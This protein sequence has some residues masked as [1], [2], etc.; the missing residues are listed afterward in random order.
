MA[1]SLA[2]HGMQVAVIHWAQLQAA[3]L[4]P[5]RL[6]Y[7][8]PNGGKRPLRVGLEMKREGLR[9]G[10]LDLNLPVPARGFVGLWVE[11]KTATGVLSTDQKWWREQLRAAGHDVQ[12]CRSIESA[13]ALLRLHA[14]AAQAEQPQ[15]WIPRPEQPEP[16]M[17]SSV[18]IAA[19]RRGVHT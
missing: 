17:K 8:I 12:V 14:L 18:P 19:S 16:T 4:H 11:M 6:L 7:A 10:V 2:E 1:R 9:K 5:L 3:V 13:I 15:V